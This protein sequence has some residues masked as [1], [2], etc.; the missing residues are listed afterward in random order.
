MFS[1]GTLSS[2]S[3]PSFGTPLSLGLNSGNTISNV[4]IENLAAQYTAVQE[5]LDLNRQLVQQNNQANQ[6]LHLTL[7]DNRSLRIENKEQARQ[8]RYVKF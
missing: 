1:P 8:L 2:P 5:L 6:S 7:E 4:A 3:H